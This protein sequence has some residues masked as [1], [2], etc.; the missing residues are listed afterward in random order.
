[1]ET[2]DNSDVVMV[3]SWW[4]MFLLK[5]GRVRTIIS[6]R[7]FSLLLFFLCLFLFS[8]DFLVRREEKFRFPQRN[9]G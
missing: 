1:M 8:R 2:E 7:E 5:E 3:S 6:G 9:P 4:W